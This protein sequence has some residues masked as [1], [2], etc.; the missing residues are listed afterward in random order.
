M[1]INTLQNVDRNAMTARRK[2]KMMAWAGIRLIIVEGAAV[3]A[4]YCRKRLS[5]VNFARVLEEFRKLCNF[6]GAVM[7]LCILPILIGCIVR[8]LPIGVYSHCG[9]VRDWIGKSVDLD[10]P[11]IF[12]VLPTG[13]FRIS[14]FDVRVG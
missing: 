2:S 8:N 7:Q 14:F 11:N 12:R 6:V 1:K 5:S 9:M 13:G 3:L 4:L 10:T